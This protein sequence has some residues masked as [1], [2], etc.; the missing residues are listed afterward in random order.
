MELMIPDPVK[1]LET[2]GNLHDQAH[3]TTKPPSFAHDGMKC[4][5]FQEA[6]CAK[7]IESLAQDRKV[8]EES[9]CTVH[10]LNGCSCDIHVP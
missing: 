1:I 5:R 4:E 9:L 8:H 6:C 7:L 2:L 3:G 10:Q